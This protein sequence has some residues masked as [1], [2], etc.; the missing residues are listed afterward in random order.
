V[1]IDGFS[2]GSST[3]NTEDRYGVL[4]A[5]VL[6]P[7]SSS[8][9]LQAMV[10][11]SQ[12]VSKTRSNT[13]LGEGNQFAVT[14]GLRYVTPSLSISAGAQFLRKED[15]GFEDTIRWIGAVSYNF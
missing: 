3:K 11:V 15:A 5:G 1:F 8:N 6:L 7:I 14:P 2:G 4:N 12:T 10:E 13:V 9:R